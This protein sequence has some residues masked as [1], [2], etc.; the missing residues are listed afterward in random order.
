VL[1]Y[2]STKYISFLTWLVDWTW[3]RKRPTDLIHDVDDDNEEEERRR[4]KRRYYF[5]ALC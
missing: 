2:T 5:A 3:R 1:T 4:R